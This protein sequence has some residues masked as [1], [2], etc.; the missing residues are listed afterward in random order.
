MA[1]FSSYGADWVDVAAPGVRIL[2]TMQDNYNTC[3]K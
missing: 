3:R 1:S 2:S